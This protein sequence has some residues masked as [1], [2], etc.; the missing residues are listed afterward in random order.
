MLKTIRK[1]LLKVD[2]IKQVVTKSLARKKW[3]KTML[4][5]GHIRMP[6]KSDCVLTIQYENGLLVDYMDGRMVGH[7]GVVPFVMRPMGLWRWKL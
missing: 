6:K 4:D 3:A 2:R 7:R 1:Q 5:G